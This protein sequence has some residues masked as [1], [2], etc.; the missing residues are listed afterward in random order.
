MPP[1]W[2]SPGSGS[3]RASSA[4]PRTQ[5]PRDGRRPD[6]LRAQPGRRGHRRP[7]PGGGLAAPLTAE[8]AALADALDFPI[9]ET[10]YEVP[11][12]M[13][14]RAVAEATSRS[15]QVS[16]ILQMYECYRKSS[17]ARRS[18]EQS[19]LD[20]GHHLGFDVTIINTQ[21]SQLLLPLRH[22]LPGSLVRRI[23]DMVESEPLPAVR[24]I[25]CDDRGYLVVPIAEEPLAVVAETDTDQVDLMVMHHLAA[26]AALIAER[27]RAQ[28][29]SRATSGGRLL[30][31]LLDGVVDRELARERLR[32]LRTGRRSVAGPVPERTAGR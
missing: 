21:E 10:A 9:I 29:E 14:S 8:A 2:R 5:L 20:L 7:G 16:M 27:Y 25:E 31:Q 12:A 4:H 1:R 26:L 19:L 24:R 18:E 32:G 30:S 22:H 11:F 17:L 6:G 15:S 13:I 28:T 23:R 3:A